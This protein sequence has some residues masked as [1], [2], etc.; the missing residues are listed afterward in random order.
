M[1][2]QPARIL[3]LCLPLCLVQLQSAAA[4]DDQQAAEIVKQAPGAEK[5]PEAG[6]LILYQE[7][8][9]RVNLDHSREL[10]D[11]LL[12]KILKDRGRS[13]GD[14]KRTYDE[15]TDSVEV[16]LARTW[17]PDGSSV[18]VEPKAINV[19]T[20]PELVGA[21]IYAD[22]KQKIISFGSIGPGAVVE[23]CTRT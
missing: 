3:L 21:A 20:P 17:L 1:K 8:V 9:L 13:Y 15:R 18:P 10:K 7:K 11:H 4:L 12:V 23:I 14:Q 16:V 2:F 19:I 6:A 5:F 22:I